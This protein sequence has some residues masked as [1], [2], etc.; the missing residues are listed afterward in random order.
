MWNRSTNCVPV[1]S[2][3][4]KQCADTFRFGWSWNRFSD[5]EPHNHWTK[6][7]DGKWGVADFDDDDNKIKDDAAIQPPFEPG[8]G[9]DESLDNR[10]WPD[11]PA[12]WPVPAPFSGAPALDPLEVEAIRAAD[13]AMNENDYA[14]KDWGSPGKQRKTY[15]SYED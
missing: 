11:W 1:H 8:K 14:Q 9:D 5:G 13:A 10:Q 2:S 3:A 12:A 6:G 7:T 4:C 15:L